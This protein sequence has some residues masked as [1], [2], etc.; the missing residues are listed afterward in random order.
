MDAIVHQHAATIRNIKL[1]T[2]MEREALRHAIL[3]TRPD[4][5]AVTDTDSPDQPTTLRYGNGRAFQQ[6]P[7]E[8]E[9]VF[10]AAARP[11]V[12]ELLNLLDAN[13]ANL[14]E[15]SARFNEVDKALVQLQVQGK[16]ITES[17]AARLTA[18]DQ[19]IKELQA[20]QMNAK[21]K[22]QEQAATIK[23]L[24]DELEQEK[25]L[26]VIGP[27]IPTE[28]PAE[29]MTPAKKPRPS[30]AKKSEATEASE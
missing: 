24:Q 28:E 30:R 8:L 17:Y 18:S 12:L 20:A 29:A 9:A 5:V 3:Q 23:A 7:N 6:K 16:E 21:I 1:G 25:A 22:E 19:T 26:K 2:A 10:F 11:I 13:T 14:A 15:L 4:I 27:I